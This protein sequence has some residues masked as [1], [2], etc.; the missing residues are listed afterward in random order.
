MP[1]MFRFIVTSQRLLGEL[2]RAFEETSSFH[3]VMDIKYLVIRDAEPMTLL[4]YARS[5]FRRGISSEVNIVERRTMEDVIRQKWECHSYISTH[6]IKR[7]EYAIYKIITHNRWKITYRR[8]K[9]FRW[10][11]VYFASDLIHGSWWVHLISSFHYFF[12]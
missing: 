1:T 4:T 9:A 6:Y 5:A 10:L 2:C 8:R 7:I 3:N 11:P 12:I